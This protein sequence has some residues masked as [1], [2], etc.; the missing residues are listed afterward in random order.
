MLSDD[1]RQERLTALN[2]L[3]EIIRPAV[4][5]DGGD[6]MLVS[7]DVTEGVVEVMLQGACSSCAV[8]SSTLQAGIDR[9]LKDRLPWVTEVKGG[10]DEDVDLEL[11]VSMGRGGYVPK[12]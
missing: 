10:V 6:L 11:S 5:A 2:E 4:Q 3:I 7:A 8:S 9:I 1:E 12:V